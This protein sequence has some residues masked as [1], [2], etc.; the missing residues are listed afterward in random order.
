M[1]L[2][3]IKTIELNFYIMEKY[4]LNSSEAILY[5]FLKN[6]IDCILDFDDILFN[7]K[8]IFKKK[9]TIYRCFKSLYKKDMISIFNISYN[10]AYNILNIEN[11]TNGCLFCSSFLN[12]HNHHFPIKKSNNGV[13]TIQ[14]CKKCHFK[15]HQLTDYKHSYIMVN[16]DIKQ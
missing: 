13:E 1:T 4:K 9:D 11:S 2:H 7:L 14:I 6:R 8:P 10:E 15:F 12:L 5:E 16:K 3:K